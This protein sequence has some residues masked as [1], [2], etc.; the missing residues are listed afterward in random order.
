M[1]IPFFSIALFKNSELSGSSCCD[2]MYLALSKTVTG[3]LND[4]AIVSA[5]SR[6]NKPPPIIETGEED[7]RR[8]LLIFLASSIVLKVSPSANGSE[9]AS[10]PVEIISLSYSIEEPS[11]RITFFSSLS[12]ESALE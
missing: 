3:K 10:E 5:S 9:I 11:E 1:E 12:M 4:V 2:N 8:T 6:P 7:S